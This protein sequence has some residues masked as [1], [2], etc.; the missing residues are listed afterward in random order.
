M[1][2]SLFKDLKLSESNLRPFEFPP[3]GFNGAL[4][5][6]FGMITLPV[7]AGSVTHDMEFVM[8]DVSS[9]YNAIVGSI[10]LHEMKA[11]AST[12]HQVV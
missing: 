10:W 12:Y 6:P 11:I 8:V 1:Y 2:Y 4:V 7:R 5:W 9:P 3:I